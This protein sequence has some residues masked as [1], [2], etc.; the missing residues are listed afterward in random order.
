MRALYDVVIVGAGPAGSTLATLLARQGWNIALLDRAVFPRDKSCAEALSPAVNLILER[1]GLLDALVQLPHERVRGFR[2]YTEG[3]RCVQ[4][5]FANAARPANHL[6]GYGVS[7]DRYHFDH[8]LV[9]AAEDAGADFCCGQRV[10]DVGLSEE[11]LYRQI[12]IQSDHHRATIAARLVVGADGV[13]SLIARRTGLH[14]AAR[15]PQVLS[16]VAHLRNVRGMT[17]YS[18]MHVGRGLYS[19]I[20]AIGGDLTNV[21]LVVPLAEGATIGGRVWDYMRRRLHQHPGIQHR[22]DSAELDRPVLAVGSLCTHP[23]RVSGDRLLLAGDAAGYYDPF[24]GE[25]VFRAMRGAELA[26]YVIHHRLEKDELSADALR[27][28]DR[29]LA[30]TFAGH[31]LVEAIVHHVVNHQWLIE[32]AASR[33][34]GRT[35]A[36]DLLIGVLGDY[37]SPSR[38]LTPC[39]LARLVV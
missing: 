24:T 30:R 36:A 28:Y 10:I 32:R 9:R 21:S 3:G 15:G 6:L 27:A 14:T 25:G 20:G 18:E 37:V 22:L 29:L 26:A 5:T 19:G 7:I 12:T 35:A 16:F 2:I 23:R 17:D 34:A 13:H 31:H 38:V 4:A 11:R 33:L 39:Y 1:L 8:M